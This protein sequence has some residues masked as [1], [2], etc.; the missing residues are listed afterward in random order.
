MREPVSRSGIWS[1]QSLQLNSTLLP[2]I[3][4]DKRGK[5]KPY[6]FTETGA[7]NSVKPRIFTDTGARKKEK[8]NI[9]TET[10]VGKWKPCIFTET[11]AT[12]WNHLYSEKQEWN[13]LYSQKQERETEWQHIFTKPVY[14]YWVIRNIEGVMGKGGI[15]TSYNIHYITPIS[16][17]VILMPTF[18]QALDTKTT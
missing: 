13:H 17:R 18:F 8:K 3:K 2:D 12:N 9:F 5:L 16:L 15:F 11:G 4:M 14:H 6:I 1:F 7:G 10:G